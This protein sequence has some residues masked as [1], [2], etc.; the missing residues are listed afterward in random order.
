MIRE[1]VQEISR[2]VILICGMIITTSN[3]ILGIQLLPRIAEVSVNKYTPLICSLGIMFQA[4]ITI[5][6]TMWFVF[7]FHKEK[8]ES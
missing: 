2:Y 1:I 8:H 4:I 5:Y 6:L 3:V 7:S